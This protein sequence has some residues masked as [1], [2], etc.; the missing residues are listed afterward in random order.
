MCR[1]AESIDQT[2]LLYVCRM[3]IDIYLHSI[4][5]YMHMGGS[6]GSKRVSYIFICIR[7][8]IYI[9]CMHTGTVGGIGNS[10]DQT[11]VLYA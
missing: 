1:D 11:Y 10:I 5:A 6:V 4:H 9:L 8:H 3:C 7:I 2:Y